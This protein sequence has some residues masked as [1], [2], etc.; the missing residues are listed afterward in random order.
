[1][2]AFQEGDTLFT[3]LK[4]QADRLGDRPFVKDAAESLSYGGFLERVRH[5]AGGLHGL[6]VRRGDAV[7]VQMP[8]GIAMASV[9][10]ACARIGAA[11]IL[12]LPGYRTGDIVPLAE[13]IRPVAWIAPGRHLGFDYVPLMKDVASACPSLASLVCLQEGVPGTVAFSSVRKAEPLADDALDAPHPSSDGDAVVICTGGTT[14]FPKPVPRTHRQLLVLAGACCRRCRLDS[15]LVYLAALPLGHVFIFAVPGLVG[16][17]L[18]AG[19]AVFASAPSTDE[20]F[21]LVEA[22][23]ATMTTLVPPLIPIWLDALSWDGSDL[24]TMDLIQVGGAPVRGSLLADLARETDCR[25]QQCYGYSEGLVTMTDPLGFSEIGDPSVQGLPVLEEDEVRIIRPDG[26]DVAVGEKGELIS[27]GPY[28][29]GHYFRFPELGDVFDDKGYI[30]SGDQA[31]WVGD[32]KFSVCG[33]LKDL[34]NK[35]GEKF[36]PL[37]IEEIVKRHPAVKDA[38]VVGVPQDD[39]AERVCAWIMVDEGA[40]GE[41]PDLGALRSFLMQEGL[42][43]YKLPELL[44]ETDSWPLSAYGKVVR[45]KLV[46][47]AQERGE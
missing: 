12:L 19:R 26:S 33:R 39:G 25:V 38:C 34:I 42:A 11:A 45:Y 28:L 36:S 8:N 35:N 10:F 31:C 43:Q 29:C 30:H 18:C 22:E 7:F 2:E 37:E 16:A 21:P 27:Q 47:M 6:G 14:G 20:I 1:M 24:S 41:M 5:V 17:M 3:V 40:D 15:T 32:G 23:G 44:Y 4:R 9:C 13:R 46:S